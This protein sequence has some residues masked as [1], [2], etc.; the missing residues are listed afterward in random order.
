MGMSIESA[1][2][3]LF[4]LIVRNISEGKITVSMFLGMTKAFYSINRRLLLNELD[5]YDVR[6]HALIFLRNLLL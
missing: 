3:K 2:C 6:G 1:V 4:D 5:F